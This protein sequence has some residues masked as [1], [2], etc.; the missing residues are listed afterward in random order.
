MSKIIKA[1]RMLV[2][3]PARFVALVRVKLLMPS[4]WMSRAARR[5]YCSLIPSKRAATSGN[6]DRL[7]FVYDTLAS[8][9]TFDFLHYL[10]YADWLRRG[11]GLSHV[12]VML[13]TR[14][15]VTDSVS[16][17][18][19]AAV[20]S[21]NLKWRLTNLLVPL[22]RLFL[23]VGRIYIVEHNE[24]FEIVK[25]YKNIHPK[26]YGYASPKPAVV[27]LDEPG[28]SYFPSVSISETARAIVQGYF[29]ATENRRILTITLRTYD[30]IS[31][32]NSDLASWL[33]FANEIDPLRYRIIFVPD[34]SPNGVAT[35]D[36]IHEHEVFDSACWNV[37]VRAAL[38]KRAWM[39]I[40]VACGPLAISALIADVWTI[41]IDRSLDYPENYLENIKS[42]GVIP[43]KTP[44]FYS[45]KCHF[46]L[47]KDDKETILK[48]FNTYDNVPS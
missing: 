48:I 32:R 35:I 46:Y 30:Y 20:G 8:P 37:E 12:D 26:G 39:N 14:F 25:G 27:R 19:V 11:A 33:E 34:A 5:I 18:Y 9:I 47:G 41:M 1:L 13:V 36:K 10:Y 40:G 2:F 17:Q 4:D 24:A 21:D 22:C 28:F 16:E 45:N 29:P 6:A 23:S 42:V 31:V 15:N 3:D 38:Y 7:L 44:N 43:G